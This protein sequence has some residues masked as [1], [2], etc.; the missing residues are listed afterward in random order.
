[1]A[2]LQFASASGGLDNLKKGSKNQDNQQ[3]EAQIDHL[4]LLIDTYLEDEKHPS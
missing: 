1:M 2:S 3:L 4:S